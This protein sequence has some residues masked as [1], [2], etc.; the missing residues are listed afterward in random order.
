MKRC[1]ILWDN[2]IGWCEKLQ[3]G[4]QKKEI[5]VYEP[6]IFS[7]PAFFDEMEAEAF[8]REWKNLTVGADVFAV[9]VSVTQL[10]EWEEQVVNQ[11]MKLADKFPKD[12]L[13][14]RFEKCVQRICSL[15]MV[16]VVLITQEACDKE[17]LWAFES[18]VWDYIERKK[19]IQICADRI[20]A[21]AKKKA[22]RADTVNNGLNEVCLNERK[23]SICFSEKEIFLTGKEYQV[24]CMLWEKKGEPVS[25][26]ELLELFWGEKQVRCQRVV[27]TLIK[28]LRHKLKDASFVIKNR[29]GRG[30]Y[31]AVNES[32]N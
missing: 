10:T 32:L 21:C 30:Y 14:S 5:E 18:G 17:E 3:K 7:F 6:E 9:V 28:Q 26:N 19:E 12:N 20:L 15:I 22:F 2:D 25:Q 23:Q 16:P 31:I 11:T 13:E 29:Y 8:Y 24:F 27:D 1:V 4:L